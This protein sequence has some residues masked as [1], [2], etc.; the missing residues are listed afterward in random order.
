MVKNYMNKVGKVMAKAYK[1]LETK[2]SDNYV[3]DG[4]RFSVRRIKIESEE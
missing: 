1:D 3:T 4:G 2:N